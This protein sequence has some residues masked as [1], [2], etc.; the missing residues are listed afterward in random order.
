MQP[1]LAGTPMRVSVISRV[2]MSKGLE[3]KAKLEP[4]GLERAG[5][6]RTTGSTL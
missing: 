2:W 6:K 1:E 5:Q 4:Y 3:W